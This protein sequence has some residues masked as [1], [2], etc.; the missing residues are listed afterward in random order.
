ML[1]GMDDR[2]QVVLV[3]A[4]D[5]A[6]GLAEKLDAHRTGA[7]HRAFSVFVF[8]PAGRTLLQRRALGKYHSGGLWSNACCSH[9]GKEGDLAQARAW[10][11]EEMG[12][13]C[14]L[15]AVDRTLYRAEVGDGLVEHEMDHVLCGVS[16]G[17]PAPNPAEVMDWQW[18]TWD[19]L[20]ADVA[21]HP[22]RYSA[23]LALLLPRCAVALARYRRAHT[24][25]GT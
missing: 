7:L 3:D 14:A 18:M 23:W 22:E 10:L 19:A 5:R 9:Q 8:D 11:R 1:R 25:V 17:T 16:A 4:A 2:S 21:H 20:A 15:A 12:L 6:L 13:D 24:R